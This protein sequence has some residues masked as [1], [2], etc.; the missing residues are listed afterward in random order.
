MAALK[1]GLA[2]FSTDRGLAPD[3]LG[4]LAEESGFESLFFP[5]HTHIPARV[6]SKIPGGS[7]M[8]PEYERTLD[9]FIALTAAA[10]ATSTL[11]M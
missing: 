6:E 8:G 3:E 7:K 5:E 4:R 10:C 1:H 9:P 11:R 2:M